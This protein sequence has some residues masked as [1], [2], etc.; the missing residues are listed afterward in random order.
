M[1][2]LPLGLLKESGSNKYVRVISLTPPGVSSNKVLT[3]LIEDLVHSTVRAIDAT[4]LDGKSCEV[5]T[6]F[7]NFTGY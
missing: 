6:D 2:I 5:L 1:Y 7:V 4:M 3:V